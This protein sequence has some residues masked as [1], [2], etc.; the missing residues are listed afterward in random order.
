M[1]P[2]DTVIVKDA[3]KVETAESVS[4]TVQD[5]VPVTGAALSATPVIVTVPSPLSVA[6][7]EGSTGIENVAADTVPPLGVM[8]S[9]ARGTMVP[10]L[11]WPTL[12]VS[13]L[14]GMIEAPEK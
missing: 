4:V 1:V 7:N 8:P 13:T 6:E 12:R 3:L 2:A 5:A 14:L 11:D 9:V 10:V